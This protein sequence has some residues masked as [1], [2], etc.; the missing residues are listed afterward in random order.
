M[1]K[2]LAALMIVLGFTLVGIAP[3]QAAVVPSVV[4]DHH[5]ST[6]VLTPTNVAPP[7]NLASGGGAKP[8]W[9]YVSCYWAMNG[10]QYCWRYSCTYFEKVALGC[11]DGWFRVSTLK[12]V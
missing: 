9:L 5:V 11:Y 12:F 8:T 6:A 7:L 3:A 4:A 1:K 2:F 10:Y